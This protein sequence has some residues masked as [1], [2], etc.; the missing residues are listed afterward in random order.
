MYTEN[1]AKAYYQATLEGNDE[2]RS[3]LYV[4]K[5]KSKSGG[6]EYKVETTKSPLFSRIL[7]IFTGIHTKYFY[8]KDALDLIEKENLFPDLINEEN[9]PPKKEVVNEE[10]PKEIV[11]EEEPKKEESPPEEEQLPKYLKK[12]EE[13]P[14]KEEPSVVKDDGFQTFDPSELVDVIPDEYTEDISLIPLFEENEN[15]IQ[16]AQILNPALREF[17]IQEVA[18]EVQELAKKFAQIPSPSSLNVRGQ[19]NLGNTCYINS[20]LQCLE[21]TYGIL[22]TQCAALI[23]KDLS[24]KEGEDLKGLE[25]RLLK[26][27]VPLTN[28]EEILFKWTYLL[29]LQAKAKGTDGDIEQALRLNHKLFFVINT[30]PEFKREIYGQKDAADYLL[31]WLEI[32]GAKMQE[33]DI[34][35]ATIDGNKRTKEKSSPT[36]NL[37]HIPL[38][39]NPH[40]T[41]I[42]RILEGC[43][44]DI[45]A[46]GKAVESTEFQVGNSIEVA[47]KY[48]KNTR[49]TNPPDALHFHFVRFENDRAHLT[50]N[51]LELQLNDIEKPIDLSSIFD[52]KA[53]Y[54]LTSFSVHGGALNT[55]HYV[56]YVLREGQWY[57]TS[58]T[59]F[60]PIEKS[61]VPFKNAYLMSFRKI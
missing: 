60:R 24:L 55:G 57:Y 16:Q 46:D 26:S 3:H 18:H 9:P 37:I 44:E 15:E 39:K 23:K 7:H 59:T 31:Y 41:L 32:L 49:Y 40:E 35:T 22:D 43:K 47:F 14:K 50:K 30:D 53:Q 38:S 36:T 48:T 42:S 51:D 25:K 12:K 6:Y 45:E 1:G 28:E 20:T 52:K 19:E 8:G 29:L 17:N 4:R 54:Q 10:L 21:T 2:A 5:M 61:E 27:W 58:D 13:P 56:A 33:V 34:I 11:K